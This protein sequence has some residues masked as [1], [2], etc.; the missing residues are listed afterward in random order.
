MI[1]R[2]PRGSRLAQLIAAAESRFPPHLADE[3]LRRLVIRI[4]A[5]SD[6]RR[7]PLLP[8]IPTFKEDGYAIQGT[9]WYA[10]YA[11]AKTPSETVA[12]L[13]KVIVQTLQRPEVKERLLG[14]GLYATGTTPEELRKIQ[15]SDSELW[16][17]AIKASGFTPK[18]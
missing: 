6:Q 1:L 12:H 5:T 18:Q 2:L 3:E 9:S 14:L 11:P 15:K 13:I 8:D 7:S 4:L 17:P 16:E 10:M